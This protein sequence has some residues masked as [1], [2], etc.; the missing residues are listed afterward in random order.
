MASRNS[1]SFTL[2]VVGCSAIDEK[3]DKVD[4][5]IEAVSK[6]VTFIVNSILIL[7]YFHITI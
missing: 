7:G 6:L 5:I 3:L 2:E 1:I 4:V